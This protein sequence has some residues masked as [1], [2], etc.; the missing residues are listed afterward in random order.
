MSILIELSSAA[1]I[2]SFSFSPGLFPIYLILHLSDTAFAKSKILYDFNFGI[3][4][5]PPVELIIDHINKFRL[6]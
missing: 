5:S 6:S 1:I 2:S 3:I 4:I